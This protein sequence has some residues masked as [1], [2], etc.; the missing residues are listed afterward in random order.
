[1]A[2]KKRRS[3]PGDEPRKKTNPRLRERQEDQEVIDA[4]DYSPG[5]FGLFRSPGRREFIESLIIAVLL[6]FMFKSFEAE[7]FI[8]PTGSMAPS[9]QGQ[10]MDLACE[11]CGYRYL[12]GASA[13]SHGKNIVATNCPICRF[14]TEIDVDKDMDHRSNSGDRILVNKFIY[15]FS[16][17][18]RFDVIVFKNPQNGKQNF[19]K[20][21]IGLPGEN[22]MIENGDIYLMTP[23]GDGGWNREICSKPPEKL[24]QVLID[25]DDTDYIGLDLAAANWP[26]RWNQWTQQPSWSVDASGGKNKWHVDS[27]GKT[28]W[29]RYRHLAPV[30]S[31]WPTI[32]SGDLPSEMKADSP[33]DLPRVD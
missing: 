27:E 2:R 12:T 28:E 24:L 31:H 17:P 16:E 29:L 32:R 4:D 23:D 3:F 33:L 13:E 20:R 11:Q 14:R 5:L 21:L 10:H 22:I 7:A 19:I 8:I 25:V 15:D 26:S 18:K 30:V 1:M 6:A 9:L